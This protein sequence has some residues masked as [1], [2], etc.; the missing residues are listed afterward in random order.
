MSS[1]GDGSSGLLGRTLVICERGWGRCCPGEKSAWRLS[2]GPKA[3][4]AS[5]CSPGVGSWSGPSVGWAVTVAYP[6]MMNIES[7]PAKP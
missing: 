2:S 1:P 6:K 7:R 5:S 3:F 4:R